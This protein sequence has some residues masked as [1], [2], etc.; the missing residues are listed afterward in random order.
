M[1]NTFKSV[2]Y[3]TTTS[4]ANTYICPSGTTAIIIGA[5]AANK[6]TTPLGFSATTNNGANVSH[7]ASNIAIP[8]SSALGFI[9]G[10]LVLEAGEYLQTSATSA[11]NVNITLSILEIT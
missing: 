5:Q 3:T 9:S 11:S 2:T 1:P 7:L 10:K 6:L 8:G 4:L